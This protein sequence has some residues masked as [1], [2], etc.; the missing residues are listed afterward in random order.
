MPWIFEAGP[1][2]LAQL[3]LLSRVALAGSLVTVRRMAQPC[4]PAPLP[5][6]IFL[7]LVSTHNSRLCSLTGPKTSLSATTTSAQQLNHQSHEPLTGV[8]MVVGVMVGSVLPPPPASH[9]LL[10][11]KQRGPQRPFHLGV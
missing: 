1:S 3:P 11:D 6:A 2:C 7:S 8:G 5:H 9:P 10:Q 4:P